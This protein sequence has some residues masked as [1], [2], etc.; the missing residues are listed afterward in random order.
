M[1]WSQAIPHTHANRRTGRDGWIAPACRGQEPD[2]RHPHEYDAS[3]YHSADEF[4]LPDDRKHV[5]VRGERTYGGNDVRSMDRY[6]RP[7]SERTEVY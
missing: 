6:S 2:R 5:L 4:S 3:G 7:G 1:A